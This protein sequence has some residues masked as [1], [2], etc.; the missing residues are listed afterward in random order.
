[1]F[2][3][4]ISPMERLPATPGAR[5]LVSHLRGRKE[6]KST[7]RALG[8]IRYWKVATNHVGTAVLSCPAEQRSARFGYRQKAVELRS[9]GQLTTAV[10]TWLVSPHPARILPHHGLTCFATKCLLELGHVL[11]HAVYPVFSRRMRIDADQHARVL[12]TPLFAPGAA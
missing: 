5:I 4:I 1:M 10:P 3:S 11:D 12:G 8:V 2:W 9:T 7:R 6:I